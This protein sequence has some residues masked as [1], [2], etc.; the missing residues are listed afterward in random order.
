MQNEAFF[1][2][3]DAGVARDTTPKTVEVATLA[4]VPRLVEMGEQLHL[5][6]DHRRFS[7]S[8]KKVATLLSSL[9]SNPETGVV[10]VTRQRGRVVGAFAGGLAPQ[11]YSEE[12]VG[13]DFS[14]FIE[15]GA[16]TGMRSAALIQAFVIWCTRRGAREVRVGITT[17][18]EVEGTSR[19]YRSLGFEDGGVGFSKE[20]NSARH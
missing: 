5:I 16:R 12:L 18:I 9:I 7:Y 19:L 4:D 2:S 14:F 1:S 3:T 6:S 20:V 17:G 13:F 10:F 15:P 11:W 8:P